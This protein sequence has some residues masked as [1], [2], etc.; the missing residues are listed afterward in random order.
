M[1]EFGAE[2]VIEGTPAEAWRIQCDVAGWPTW[3]SHELAARLDGA[4]STGTHGWSKPRGAPAAD[5]VL[6]A[7]DEPRSWSSVSPL[8]GGSLTNT[9]TFTPTP[10]GRLA[11]TATMRATGPLE[12]LFRVWFGPRIRRAMMTTFADLEAEILRRR[13]HGPTP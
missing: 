11:C 1:Y 2:A 5:W 12:L 7:V 9:R 6:T 13:Q 4:F 3:D 8:P 10:D